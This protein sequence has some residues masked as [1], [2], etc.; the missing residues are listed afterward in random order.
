MAIR[1]TSSEPASISTPASLY[2]KPPFPIALS[3]DSFFDCENM[4]L[5]RE[6]SV[7]GA[8]D[9]PEKV[10]ERDPDENLHSLVWLELGLE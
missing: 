4:R 2:V 6:N 10:L 3:P 5:L 7:D 8:I 9:R 1:R